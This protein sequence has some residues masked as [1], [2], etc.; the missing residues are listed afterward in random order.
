MSTS[1]AA[2]HAVD[3]NDDE[4]KS[5][6][7]ELLLDAWDEALARGCQPELIA[8]SAVFAAITDMIDLYGE[9]PVAEMAEGLPQRIRRGEFSMREGQAH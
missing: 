4:Q 2:V 9:D 3:M 8:T 6:A 5:L 1:N 7:L